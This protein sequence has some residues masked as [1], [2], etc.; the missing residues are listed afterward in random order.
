M[1]ELDADTVAQDDRRR[2]RRIDRFIDMGINLV[3]QAVIGRG[4]AQ[5]VVTGVAD[6]D[7]LRSADRGQCAVGLEQRGRIIEAVAV[8]PPNLFGIDQ[9]PPGQGNILEQQKPKQGPGG[10]VVMSGSPSV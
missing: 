2:I 8:D 5:P 7:G 1:I 6:L 9:A 4:E 3:R 10:I